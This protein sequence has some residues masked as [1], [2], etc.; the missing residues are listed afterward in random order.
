[1]SWPEQRQWSTVGGKKNRGN[2]GDVM[3]RTEVA[4]DCGRVGRQRANLGGVGSPSRLGEGRKGRRGGAEEELAG[5]NALPEARA[6]GEARRS[7]HGG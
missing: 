2:S 6:A 7:G 4:M 1:M 3:A 5:G